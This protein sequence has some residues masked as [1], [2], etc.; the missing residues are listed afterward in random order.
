MGDMLKMFLSK[1]LLELHEKGN[2]EQIEEISRKF[3][4][5]E[6]EFFSVHPAFENF[7]FNAKLPEKPCVDGIVIETKGKCSISHDEIKKEY[8]I[9]ELIKMYGENFKLSD[10]PEGIRIKKKHKA[11][12]FQN[13]KIKN[14]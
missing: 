14:F 9:K 6:L 2:I 8:S 5:E 11:K 4:K 7:G 13:N 10:L 12:E 3:T 1:K